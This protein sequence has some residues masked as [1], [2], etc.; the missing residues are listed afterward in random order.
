MGDLRPDILEARSH[1]IWTLGSNREI[2]KLAAH[3]HDDEQVTDMAAGKYNTGRGLVVLTTKRVLFIKDG[4][5]SQT[6]QEFAFP[7]ISSVEWH[8]NLF[9]GDIQIFS[10]GES[11]AHIT[12]VWKSIGTKM[13][14]QIS[15]KTGREP[16]PAPQVGVPASSLVPGRPISPFGSA[17]TNLE[18]PQAM[19]PDQQESYLAGLERLGNL[20]SAGTLTQE[21]FDA[22]KHKLLGN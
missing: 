3:L 4:W 13:V 1:M 18:T 10:T 15:S 2:R 17:P 22:A 9:F 16:A 5:F 6:T 11:Q 8:A 14:T 19:T 20:R 7:A 12:G 21:E